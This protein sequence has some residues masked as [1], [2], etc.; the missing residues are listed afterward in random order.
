M[1]ET[2]NKFLLAGDWFMSEMHL[3]LKR[4]GSQF[5]P[6]SSIERVELWVFVTFN[7]IIRHVFPENFKEIHQ[8][9]QRI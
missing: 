8:I 2:V 1:N 6:L 7:I 5:D 3:T 4:R 9:A